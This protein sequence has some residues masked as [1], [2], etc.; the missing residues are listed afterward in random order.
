MEHYF[1]VIECMDLHTQIVLVLGTNSV[2]ILDVPVWPQTQ[3]FG[4]DCNICLV[5]TLCVVV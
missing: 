5:K 3:V 1:V 4:P 2:G